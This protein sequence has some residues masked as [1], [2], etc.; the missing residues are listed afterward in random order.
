MKL[1]AILALGIDMIDGWLTDEGTKELVFKTDDGFVCHAKGTPIR[2]IFP[3]GLSDYTPE[4]HRWVI[5]YIHAHQQ[6][7]DAWRFDF[8][9]HDLITK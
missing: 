5:N 4:E 1:Y 9:W 8:S 6:D 3:T 2:K 7:P